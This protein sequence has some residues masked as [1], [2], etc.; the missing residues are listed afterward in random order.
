MRRITKQQVIDALKATIEHEEWGSPRSCPLCILFLS[1]PPLLLPK[2]KQIAEC[3]Q[4]AR[5]TRL[6]APTGA[7]GCL[8]AEPMDTTDQDMNWY[9]D[10]PDS[11]SAK[12]WREKADKDIQLCI[13]DHEADLE[14]AAK[15]RVLKRAT[16]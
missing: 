12:E 7:M 5:R 8:Q 6:F 4:C 3:N 11:K 15:R 2:K 13:Y 10:D 16:I 1:A 9:F 14:D